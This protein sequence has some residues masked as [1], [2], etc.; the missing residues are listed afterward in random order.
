[1]P[2]FFLPRSS[3][4]DVDINPFK[5]NNLPMLK[6]SAKMLSANEG[7]QHDAERID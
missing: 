3:G 7:C 4:A 6:A 2:A 5:M 1:M